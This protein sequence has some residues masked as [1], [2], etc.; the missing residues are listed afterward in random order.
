LLY[1]VNLTA[2]GVLDN[3]VFPERWSRS[4]MENP[5]TAQAPKPKFLDQVRHAIRAR[6]YNQR[7]E[8]AY[9]PGSSKTEEVVG[10]VARLICSEE[11]DRD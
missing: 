2:L 7:T 11:V 3:I 8:E 9:V 5:M 6:H 1:R 10:F 4:D